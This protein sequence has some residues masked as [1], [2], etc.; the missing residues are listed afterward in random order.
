MADV[1]IDGLFD[2]AFLIFNTLFNLQT[3]ADQVRCFQN[4]ATKLPKGGTF[5]IEAYV[6]RMDDFT[7]H[8]RVSTKALT[9]DMVKLEALMHDPVRQVFDMQRI[10]AANALC[11][12]AGD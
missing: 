10:A 5:V 1:E 2:H 4:V 11:L 6:P 9:H 12:S 8:Q 7:N 3:Q